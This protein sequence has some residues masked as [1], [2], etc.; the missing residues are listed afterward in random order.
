MD[1]IYKL[2][3]FTKC[4]FFE[5][6]FEYMTIYKYLNRSCPICGNSFIMKECQGNSRLHALLVELGHYKVNNKQL[7]FEIKKTN[8]FYGLVEK[9]N[10][11]LKEHIKEVIA[12]VEELK[13]KK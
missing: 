5:M 6:A 12:Q 4:P 7:Q 3:F 10:H 2:K 11:C 13:I 8:Y 9:Y 1:F